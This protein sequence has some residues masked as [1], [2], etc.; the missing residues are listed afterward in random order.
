MALFIGDYTI[1][2]E[3][4]VLAKRQKKGGHVD[5]SFKQKGKD[6]I[7]FTLLNV[8]SS[9]VMRGMELSATSQQSEEETKFRRFHYF[10]KGHQIL[11]KPTEDG[12]YAIP[13]ALTAFSND[14]I[15][16]PGI[17][18]YPKDIIVIISNQDAPVNFTIDPRNIY[19][20]MTAEVDGT[21]L[22]DIILVKYGNWSKLK[23][24]AYLGIEMEY[25]EDGTPKEITQC[26]KFGSTFFEMGPKQYNVDAL[27]KVPDKDTKTVLT[28][29]IKQIDE[30]AAKRAA[31]AEKQ[32]KKREAATRT[33]PK[34]SY[35]PG[36]NRGKKP[37]NN[38]GK[39]NGYKKSNGNYRPKDGQNRPNNRTQNNNRQGYNKPYKKDYQNND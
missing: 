8:D 21:Y 29:L 23:Y 16:D 18:P 28:E 33:N 4:R 6:P 19:G 34:S 31:Y 20:T 17:L 11:V 13:L 24:D 5:I 1:N 38:N 32:K 14:E 37:Y 25:E 22:V 15:K 3:V 9:N 39:S 30:D 10:D 26:Y 36:N 35:K 27:V 7:E 12:Q 2:T